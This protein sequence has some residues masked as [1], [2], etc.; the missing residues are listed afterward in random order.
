MKFIYTFQAYERCIIWVHGC[1]AKDK[2]YVSA[3]DISVNGEIQSKQVFAYVM[4]SMISSGNLFW[5]SSVF[6]I[7]VLQVSN[8]MGKHFASQNDI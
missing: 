4:P 3:A 8:I 6:G 2:T 7:I 1:K 5:A